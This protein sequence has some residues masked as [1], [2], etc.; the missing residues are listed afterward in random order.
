M[1]VS[2]D[3]HDTIPTEHLLEVLGPAVLASIRDPFGIFSSDFRILWANKALAAIHQYQ[4]EDAIGKICYQAFSKG[5]KP[6]KD[7]PM[8]PVYKTGRTHIMEKW[9]DFPDGVRRFG[10]VR[11]YP[12]RGKNREIVAIVMIIIETTEKKQQLEEQKKYAHF[13]AGKLK[14]NNPR[15]HQ[16]EHPG[17]GACVKIKLSKRETEILRLLAEGFT[18]PQ[19][20]QMLAVSTNTI[21]SYVNQIFNKL[22][23]SDRTQA[24]VL[25]VRNKII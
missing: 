24:A 12:I 23:V 2:K 3:T 17:A 15:E 25:A 7:C 10:E 19:I 5:E 22:G 20:S 4:P 1:V 13:L 11:S 16:I 6:C 18:N 9:H 8:L 14:E 21:K